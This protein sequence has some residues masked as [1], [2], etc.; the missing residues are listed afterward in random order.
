MSITAIILM[1]AAI[2]LFVIRFY[3]KKR[4]I[5][6]A[7]FIISVCGMCAVFI[8]ESLDTMTMVVT[9]MPLIFISFMCALDVMGYGGKK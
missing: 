2:G 9:V 6:W 1:C 3:L 7:T 8:D 5:N 4:E